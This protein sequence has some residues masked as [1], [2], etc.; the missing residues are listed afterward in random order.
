MAISSCKECGGKVSTTAA[1][2]PHCGAK[3]PEPPKKTSIFT[4]IVT[5]F[6]ALVVVQIVVVSW[7]ADDRREAARAA[8]AARVAAMTPAQREA[9]TMKKQA[10]GAADKLSEELDGA[11]MDC[12]REITKRLKD[13]DSAK[14]ADPWY[15][16]NPK[17]NADKTFSLVLQVRAK[18]SFGAYGLSNYDCRVKMNNGKA[19]A[20]SV[21]DL[22]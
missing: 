9:E 17:Q 1:A 11:A 21:A 2:C 22:K 10:K 19:T 15:R 13:P 8:E 14:W 12:R 6:F 7:G 18:N 16:F 20:V 4:W 5:G 3:Q